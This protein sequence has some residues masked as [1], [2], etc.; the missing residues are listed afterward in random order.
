MSLVD[1]FEKYLA[2][3]VE[4]HCILEQNIY[5]TTKVHGTCFIKFNHASRSISLS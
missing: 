2:L 3:R 5:N 1:Y 4:A